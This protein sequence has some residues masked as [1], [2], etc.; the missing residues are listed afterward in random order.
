MFQCV[1]EISGVKICLLSNNK[2]LLI[3]P[4]YFE[5]VVPESLLANYYQIDRISNENEF[6]ARVIMI[7]RPTETPKVF[8][9]SN[10]LVAVADFSRLEKECE[11]RR[12]AFLGTQGILYR[13]HLWI[14]EKY[15][16]IYSFHSASLFDQENERFLL[17]LGGPNSG[18][19]P[20]LLAGVSK[21][22]SV[23]GTDL[24]HLKL[25]DEGYI[26]Y[27]CGVVDNIRPG[28]IIEHFPELRALLKGLSW[29]G[30]SGLWESKVAVDFRENEYPNDSIKNPKV[31]IIIPRIEDGKEKV[32]I[33]E[34][35]SRD[36]LAKEL[37][38]RAS[39]KIGSTGLMYDSFPMVG[40]DNQKQ[41]ETRFMA[42]KK[43]AEK[44]NL[45]RAINFIGSPG[46][47]REIL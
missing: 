35:E 14:L 15:K 28:H 17:V 34:I 10:E 47:C 41:A 23:F 16:G 22:F 21:G 2:S 32:I 26:F 45:I 44:M 31:E 43:L 27:R 13:F 36:H 5:K 25:V 19:T 24:T 46:K 11:D 40:F 7:D 1:I 20:V 18:K 3:N 4:R 9:E 6:D 39:E 42:M 8:M 33:N 38:E 37:F 30:D 12:Y 29:D